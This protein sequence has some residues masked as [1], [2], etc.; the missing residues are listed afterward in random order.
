MF[1]R[2]FNHLE[3]WLLPKLRDRK[4]S[5]EK[6]ANFVGVSRAA[7]YHWLKDE[8]RPDPETMVSVCQVLGVPLEEG[9]RQY[10]PRPEGR[11]GQKIA[12]TKRSRQS[13][14]L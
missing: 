10:T 8:T 5:V 14:A 7:V 11:P 9:L 1:N 3:D 2:D 4:L 12:S 6:F 13:K